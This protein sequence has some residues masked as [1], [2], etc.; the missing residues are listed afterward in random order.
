[1]LFTNGLKQVLRGLCLPR[2]LLLLPAAE[3]P[4]RVKGGSQQLEHHVLIYKS[5]IFPS[6]RI[7]FYTCNT[8]ACFLIQVPCSVVAFDK[9]KLDLTDT[10]AL[11]GDPEHLVEQLCPNTEVPELLKKRNRDGSS[12]PVLHSGA[13]RD[14]TV[15]GY[16]PIDD[17]GDH[18]RVFTPVS[19]VQKVFFLFKA[20]L[21][22]FLWIFH[23][24]V[25]LTGGFY[26]ELE[27]FLRIVLA[28]TAKQGS[29]TVF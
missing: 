16:P 12:V 28:R 15:S 19:A 11:S 10:A 29:A 7:R 5:T 26:D 3:F 6:Y 17:A 25:C 18:H 23:Q 8:K 24:K 1:M 9:I 2:K 4:D 22:P 20:E 21:S 27:H 14:L 13:K